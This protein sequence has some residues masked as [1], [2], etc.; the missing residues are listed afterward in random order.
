L[1]ADVALLLL[2][3]DFLAS[4]FLQEVEV[5]KLV[6]RH[7][8]GSLEVIPVL[9]RSCL[10]EAHPWLRTLAPL[11]AS[12]EPVASFQGDGRD[13]ALKEV[14]GGI[15]ARG[16][17]WTGSG[18]GA[19][20]VDERPAGEPAETIFELGATPTRFFV[21]REQELVEVRAAFTGAG[22]PGTIVHAISGLA[23]VGK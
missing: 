13:R 6:E 11:P 9:A 10:W 18:E 21:G 1:L 15:A 17:R 2:S 20:R 4:D 7:Q 8:R 12:R 19:R 5:P 14:V 22:G 16:G 23:G 3:K